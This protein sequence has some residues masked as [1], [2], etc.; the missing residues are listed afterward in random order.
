MTSSRTGSEIGDAI[1]LFI[2]PHQYARYGFHYLRSIEAL[3][4]NILQHFIKVSHV[5]RPIKGLWN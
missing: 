4:E 1:F 3:P 5:M 2:R